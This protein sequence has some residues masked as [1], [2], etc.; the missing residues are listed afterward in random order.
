MDQEVSGNF[1]IRGFLRAMVCV[2]VACECSPD[3]NERDR[4]DDG[5]EEDDSGREREHGSVLLRR[6]TGFE[7]GGR[8]KLRPFICFEIYFPE[9]SVI[10]DACRAAPEPATSR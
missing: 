9:F 10:E 7:K 8:R 3:P 1:G 4:E 5:E 6:A 2:A